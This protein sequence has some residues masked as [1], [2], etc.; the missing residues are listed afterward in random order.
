MDPGPPHVYKQQIRLSSH[1]RTNNY[2]IMR[3]LSAAFALLF[4]FLLHA[5]AFDWQWSTSVTSDATIAP[6][7]Y[8]MT[9]DA[10][11][12]SY[13]AGSFYGTVTFGNLS[14]ITSGVQS[15][16]Y[17]V[18]YDASG[19]ALWAVHAGGDSFD[20]AMAVSVDGAGNVYLT[21]YYQSAS[22]DFGAGPLVRQGFSDIF[23]AKYSADGEFQWA[24]DYG[25]TSGEWETGAAIV[26][27]A[28]GDMYVTGI[29]H[30][31]LEVPGQELL[32]SCM[33]REDMFLLKLDTDG[34]ALWSKRPGCTH[35][36]SYGALKGDELTLDAFGNL[37]VGARLRGD[38]V[39][40]ETDTVLNDAAGNQAEDGILAKYDADGNF[41]WARGFGGY[42]YDEIRAL[43]TDA[44]GH[45]YLAV[46]RESQ[47]DLPEFTLDISGTLGIYRGVLLKSDPNGVFE[48]G[49]RMGNNS[50]NTDLSGL[51]LDDEGHL[52][53]AGQFSNR[54]E[55]D[56]IV[57]EITPGAFYGAFIAQYDT[58][59]SAQ[60]VWVTRQN[61]PRTVNG[62]GR[63]LYGNI[64]AA[65]GFHDTL[66]FAGTPT[67][68]VE[69]N[70][71]YLARSGDINTGLA[72][73]R[74]DIDGVRVFPVP[75][76]GAFTVQ[77]EGP[78][79]GLQ[80]VNALGSVV[81]NER[82][83]P[84]ALR[85]VDLL[86]SGVFFYTLLNGTERVGSGRVVIQR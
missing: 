77:S 32:E 43:E 83:P 68:D 49:A 46:H 55:W 15:D 51:V 23:V 57:S 47:Y 58:E 24:N 21:G 76:N 78:F 10:D 67:L 29:F 53:A 85:S 37:Y 81:L 82:F 64:Y 60:E 42:G 75:S 34:N 19:T 44:D 2:S 36:D 39:F 66:T 22:L 52:Y 12:N 84:T 26:A 5:Q 16:L 38:T 30:N 54:C 73:E 59:G 62:L 25:S 63:D 31:T 14:P 86:E 45:C 40:F 71:I 61:L 41:L 48:W 72:F 18:K 50:Y 6:N 79:T 74:M 56:G 9:T 1:L 8:S 33:P 11:G 3:L 69:D 13:V 35:D 80:I 70:A 17:V 4:T 65:G 20:E 7:I 28:N 27:E